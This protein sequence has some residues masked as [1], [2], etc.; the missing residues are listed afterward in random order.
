[1]KNE[2]NVKGEL[3]AL[4]DYQDQIF[5]YLTFIARFKVPSS[6]VLNLAKNRIPCL[7]NEN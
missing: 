6:L 4:L 5:L 7:V 2:M 1:M 3:L